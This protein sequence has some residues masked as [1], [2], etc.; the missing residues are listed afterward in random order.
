MIKV[1][2]AVSG[3]PIQVS[4]SS[5]G[6][7]SISPS[8]DLTDIQTIL[9]QLSDDQLEEYTS[10]LHKLGDFP[11]KVQINVLTM[12]ADDYASGYAQSSS[13]IYRCIRDLLISTE[14][15]PSRKLPLVYVIDSI[16][17]N[18]KGN[19]IALMRVD[20]PLWMPIVHE[21]LSSSTQYDVAKLKVRKVWNTWK[22]FNIFPDKDWKEMGNPFIQEDERIKA[23]KLIADVRAKAAGFSKASDGT[24]ILSPDLRKHMQDILDDIQKA[25]NVDELNKVSLERLADINQ[26]LLLEIKKTAEEIMA[27]LSSSSSHEKS[28]QMMIDSGGYSSSKGGGIFI[29]IRPPHVLDRVRDWEHANINL[30]EST[31]EIITKLNGYVKMG[32]NPNTF[33]DENDRMWIPDYHSRNMNDLLGSC[34]ACTTL[35]TSMLEKVQ[36][37]ESSS[38]SI[39]SMTRPTIL[40]FEHQYSNIIGLSSYPYM[41]P[42]T[43]ASTQ[44]GVSKSFS[45]EFLREKNP[46]VIEQLYHGGLPFLSSTDGRRFRKEAELAAHLDRLF[47]KRLLERSMERSEDRGWYPSIIIWS[48]QQP[49]GGSIDDGEV[50]GMRNSNVDSSVTTGKNDDLNTAATV[51]ADELRDRCVLCGLNFTMFLD[52]EQE[53]WKYN[54]CY[55]IKVLHSDAVWETGSE[56]MLVHVSCLRGLGSPHVLYMDQIIPT[57]KKIKY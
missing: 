1:A 17:K 38:K 9:P 4:N 27:A 21:A 51:A 12:I 54:N 43:L 42:Q 33:K 22:E 31:S 35:L 5:D 7:K 55:E 57:A 52:Q 39:T 6:G 15:P 40:S 2:A 32:T 3:I 11:D 44:L 34:S 26:D 37:Q 50:R 20:I 46:W 29:E 8:P 56:L 53:E 24:L 30:L 49:A 45:P 41:I 48:G 16:L 10:L 25:E 13:S 14:V 23:S 47:K 28:A 18:V 19:Y 36:I